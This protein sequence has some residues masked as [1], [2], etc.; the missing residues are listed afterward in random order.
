MTPGNHISAAEARRRDEEL[1]RAERR[2]RD[3]SAQIGR[4]IDQGAPRDA[5][6]HRVLQKLRDDLQAA[7]VE[8]RRLCRERKAAA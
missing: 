7:Q 2:M 8:Y 6:E 3:A 5:A 1:W 4:L